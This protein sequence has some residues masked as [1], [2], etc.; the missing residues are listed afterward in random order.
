MSLLVK[1]LNRYHE[2]RLSI[3]SMAQ[4]SIK[5]DVIDD[6]QGLCALKS[7]WNEIAPPQQVEPWKSYNWIEAAAL[8]YSQNH[9]WRI[10][11]TRSNGRLTGIAPLVLKP[12]NQALKP[13]QLHILGGEEL[14]EPN[15]LIAC[16]NQSL[17]ALIDE[18]A[19]EPVYPIRLSR[20]SN[21]KKSI[22]LL[23]EKFLKKGWFIKMMSLPYPYIDLPGSK[24]KKSLKNDL[25]RARK[26]AQ[27]LGQLGVD[28]SEI[29]D[30]KQLSSILNTAFS[31]EASGWKGGNHT[32]ILS[33][34]MRKHF[35]E[36][37]ARSSLRD[38]IFR[39]SF[40]LID[41]KPV[42]V[43]Y[44]VEAMKA[45]WLL[46]IGYDESVRSCSP[47]N[48]LLDAS[49]KDSLNRGLLRYNLLGKEEPWTRRW[50]KTTQDC[51]VFAAYRSNFVG[52][53]AML[54]D[55]FWLINKRWRDHKLNIQKKRH[56]QNPD[57]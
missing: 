14:K 49:I 50:T 36:T 19:S 10:I 38:D 56:R 42:A 1:D 31:I 29:K 30:A 4:N 28:F 44:A 43:Q 6:Y 17:N 3:H 16:D 40:L 57:Q 21:D 15:Q 13:R 45:Y 20:I 51:V 25:R 11:T 9:L 48:L 5:T 34:Q 53:K 27:T 47:G 32:A 52:A 18:M 39:I 8:A 35:F 55:A 23:Y 37:Y 22:A 33:D 24:I 46:N 26:K 2:D 54:S 7:E 41:S 12:S